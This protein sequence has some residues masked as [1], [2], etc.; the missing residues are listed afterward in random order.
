MVRLVR[1][2]GSKPP[3]LSPTEWCFRGQARKS[4][5]IETSSW[6]KKSGPRTVRLVRACGSKLH[7][8]SFQSVPAPGQAR[9]SLWIET[10]LYIFYNPPYT[11]QARKSLWIETAKRWGCQRSSAVRLVRACGSKLS[12]DHN[13]VNCFVGQARKSLWIETR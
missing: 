10:G 6:I 7:V 4:L 3:R 13:F 12:S 2:C 11:G 9:K 8:C 5:W 1:A